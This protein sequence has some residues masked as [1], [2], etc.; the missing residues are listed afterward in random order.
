MKGIKQV[1]NYR[2]LK[3]I[4]RGTSGIVYEAVDDSNGKKYAVK[5]I[6]SSKLENKR[7][8]DNFKRELRLLYSL[9][10]QNIIKITGIEKTVNNTYLALE[11]CNGGN[12]YDYMAYHK[13][14]YGTPL[15]EN[16]V[17]YIVRQI[18]NG[19]EYM[20][21][22]KI[23]HRDI[24]LENILLNFNSINNIHLPNQEYTKLDYSKHSIFNCTI[25]IADLGYA[26]E[27]DGCSLASTICGTPMT[28]APDLIHLGEKKYNSKADLWS[29]G[30]ITYE[31]ITGNLPFFG[32]NFK[33]L[34]ENVMK[35]KY[36][37]PNSL[38]ISLEII[39]FINGLLQYFPHKRY[40]WKQI[41]VHPFISNELSTFTTIDLEKIEID[42]TQDC[43]KLQNDTKDCGNFLWLLFKS[44]LKNITLD[45]EVLH[46]FLIGE[47]DGFRKILEMNKT[48][49]KELQIDEKSIN[50]E[51]KNNNHQKD[52]IV[53]NINKEALSKIDTKVEKESIKISQNNNIL[54]E[55]LKEVLDEK[56]SYKQETLTK[57]LLEEFK[58]ELIEEKMENE[59][60][61][62]LINEKLSKENNSNIHS[63]KHIVVQDKENCD[64]NDEIWE[65]LS[66]NSIS[67]DRIEVVN[68]EQNF[69][70]LPDYFNSK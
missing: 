10:H 58:K 19:L 2:L 38:K 27:L 37:F 18:V 7:I 48:N 62:D 13:Q 47:V 22:N 67:E 9:N 52:E 51:S 43:E 40:D 15:P 45:K 25:K 21:K 49:I 26:R 54:K 57:V 5:S 11:F 53:E 41:H 1:K 29:L 20:H 50:N 23:I 66:C 3:E 36:S 6:P 14:K 8:L 34:I 35:G 64:E 69:N 63:E 17:Q 24:K 59:K 61:I 32:N 55:D 16:Q 4:G 12:L 65:I 44:S 30:A 60:E 42:D 46:N 68:F 39:V 31:L 56:N 28:M 33:H 70:I